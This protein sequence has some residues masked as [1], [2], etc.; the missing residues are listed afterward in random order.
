M[1]SFHHV[2]ISVTNLDKSRQ[3]YEVLGFKEVMHFEHPD[4]GFRI[5]HMKLGKGFLELFWFPDQ[6]VID[7]QNTK[8]LS[9]IGLKH[10]ALQVDSIEDA[11]AKLIHNHPER[12]LTISEGHTGVRYLFIEDPDGINIEIIED[13]RGL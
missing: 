6:Q 11:K 4:D 3:F 9:M 8:S 1:F 10:F 13:H 5:S 7:Q 2:A 12:N